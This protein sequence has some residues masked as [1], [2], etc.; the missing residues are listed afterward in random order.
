MVGE[1]VKE[2]VEKRV[3]N[4]KALVNDVKV[5]VDLDPSTPKYL[6]EIIGGAGQRFAATNRETIKKIGGR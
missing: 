3:G 4:L 5:R 1:R 6:L 2:G